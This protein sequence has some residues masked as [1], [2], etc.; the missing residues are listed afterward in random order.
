MEAI[1]RFTESIDWI[2]LIIFLCLLSIAVVRQFTTLP[3]SEF[4]SVYT[5]SRFV[6]LTQDGRIDN[7]RTYQ[8]VGVV[9]YATAISLLIYKITGFYQATE[10]TDFILIWT[11]VSSFFL[12]KH[13]VSKLVATISDF[14][15]LMK[16][17]DHQRNLYRAALSVFLMIAVIINFYVFPKNE[18]AI[19]ITTIT[20]AIVVLTYHSLLIYSH[21]KIVLPSFFY[22]I[23]YLCTLEMA[24]YLLL[25]KYFTARVL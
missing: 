24:P 4:L 12:F 23:L 6:K 1:Y 2:T 5:S 13:Y 10:F 15:E 17:V 25:Y 19:L 9:V 11:A 3:L 14:E 7:Y 18:Q 22:F 21:R 8:N 16:V 20:A